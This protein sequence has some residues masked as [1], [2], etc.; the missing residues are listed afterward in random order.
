[1]NKTLKFVLTL[2]AAVAVLA[3]PALAGGEEAV[4]IQSVPEPATLALL[5]TGVGVVAL[6]RRLRNK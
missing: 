4:R 6:V 1:M 5:A 3:I 2:T